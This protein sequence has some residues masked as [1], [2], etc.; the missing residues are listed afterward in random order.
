MAQ[1]Q[2]F[3]EYQMVTDYINF[4][5]NVLKGNKYLDKD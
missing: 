1:C 4:S 3:Y 2:Q 5:G